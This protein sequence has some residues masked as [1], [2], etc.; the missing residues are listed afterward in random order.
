M[1]VADAL[2]GPGPVSRHVRLIAAI[3]A[4]IALA[5]LGQMGMGLTDT[6]MLGRIGEHALAAGGLGANFF[7]TCLFVLQGIVSGVPVLAARA[8]GADQAGD[9]APAYWSGFAMACALALPFFAL[10]TYPGPV[11][12]LAGE[13][14]DLIAG[15]TEYLSVLRWGVPA[16][17]LGFGIIRAFLPAIGL[18]RLLLWVI[19]AGVGLNAALNIWLIGGGLGVPALGMRGSAA[20]TT[21]TLW[22]TTLALFALL[23]GH[24][25]WRHHVAPAVPRARMIGELLAIGAPV[26]VTLLVEAT[27][28]LVTALLAGQLG[29]QP[30]AAHMVA[31]NVASVT[32]M[33]PLAVSQAANVRVAHE[34]GAGHAAAAR[35]AGLTALGLSVAFMA[36]SAALMLTASD[37]IARLYLSAASPAL[38]VTAGLLRVAGAFQVMDGTQVTAAGALRGLKDTRVPMVLAAIGYWGIGFPVGRHLAFAEGGGV[39]GLWWGLAAGLAVTAIALTWRFVAASRPAV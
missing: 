30:L 1:P 10:M 19:P 26:S 31:I 38:P 5:Q 23:H 35:R 17:M 21:L 13:G 36:C 27:L 16:G 28:F 32:F 29:A 20:A 3:A 12:R 6:L 14:P 9:I 24:R 39:Q 25:S 2:D 37:A 8:R 15:I 22:I 11:L 33:V 18:E 7:F 34:A 4:P